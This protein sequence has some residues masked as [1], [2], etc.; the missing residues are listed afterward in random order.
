MHLIILQF[1]IHDLQDFM[2]LTDFQN[3]VCGRWNAVFF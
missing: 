3:I 1:T 2:I